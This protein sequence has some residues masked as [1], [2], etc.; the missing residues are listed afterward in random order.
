MNLAKYLALAVWGGAAVALALPPVMAQDITNHAVPVGGG[1]G[2]VGWKEAGPCSAGETLVWSSSSADPVCG[3]G[4]G[5]GSASFACAGVNDTATIQAVLNGASTTVV[6]PSGTC[7]TTAALTLNSR[8]SISC[9]DGG[10]CIL[11][12]VQPSGTTALTAFYFQSAATYST[13]S[14]IKITYACATCTTGFAGVI[15]SQAQYVT[16]DKMEI[17]GNKAGLLAGLLVVGVSVE[18]SNQIITNSF[19]HDT[20]SHGVTGNGAFSNILVDRNRIGTVGNTSLPISFSGSVSCAEHDWTFSNNYLDLSSMP[21]TGYSGIF[22]AGSTEICLVERVRILNNDCVMPTPPGTAQP[23]CYLPWYINNGLIQGNRAYYG[24]YAYTIAANHN[25]L[26]SQNASIGASICGFEMGG[27]NL[28][29]VNN[30]VDGGLV[31]NT[32]QTPVQGTC[33]FTSN[34]IWRAISTTA[35]NGGAIQITVVDTNFWYTGQL[36]CVVGVL[37]TVEANNCWTITVDNATHITLQGSAIKT[38]CTAGACGQGVIST[39]WQITAKDNDIANMTGIGIQYQYGAT[40]TTAIGNKITMAPN[41]GYACISDSSYRSIIVG[42]SCNG[43]SVPSSMDVTGMAAAAGLIR[44]TVASTATL[45][46]NSRVVIQGTLGTNEANNRLATPY[47]PVTVLGGGVTMDLQ[48]STFTNAYTGGGYIN[49]TRYGILRFASDSLAGSGFGGGVIANNSVY[50]TVK[51]CV[52]LEVTNVTVTNLNIWGN[53]CQNTVVSGVTTSLIGTGAIASTVST[54]NVIPNGTSGGVPTY[55][56]TGTL[57]SSGVLAANLP[58]IGGGAGAVIA[59]GTRSGTTTAF[60]TTTGAQT[61][62]DCVKIDASGN[63]VANGSSCGASSGVTINTTTITGGAAASVLYHTAGNVVGEYTVIGTASVCM[64]TNC[65]MTTPTL[66]AATATTINKVTF[67]APATGSTLTIADGKTALFNNTMAF[68]AGADGQTWTFPAAGAT[69]LTTNS[70]ATLTNKTFDT[71]ATGNALAL[72][73]QSVTSVSGNT[74][75]VVTTTGTL[76]SGDCV[77]IDASG[78]FIANGAACGSATSA[79]P[80]ATIGLT[81]VNGSA[82]TFL[83]SDGAPALSVAIAPTWTG[84]HTFNIGTTGA[85]APIIDAT[86]GGTTTTEQYWVINLGSNGA[87]YGG[88]KIKQAGTQKFVFYYNPGATFTTFDVGSAGA[89]PAAMKLYDTGGVAFGS[90]ATDPGAG[91]LNAQNGYVSGGNVGVD[92]TGIVAGTVTVSKGIV[93]HC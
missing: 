44:V 6:F 42:N 20:A 84:L 30:Y 8:K 83:R 65:I 3:A 1:P 16:I 90:T 5:G 21:D 37:L 31:V 7:K 68:S 80:S 40:D 79:N 86:S 58:L 32:V 49:M 59:A 23:S 45:T 11:Q 55:T 87:S 46:T 18:A 29:M 70:T 38:T 41:T 74:A 9:V 47:W 78:N 85:A 22:A 39:S 88:M 12:F 17:D 26:Y 28:S 63:H 36:A 35:S 71:A 72:G 13:I 25:T 51:G 4:G 93:T 75:K 2:A 81:A 54:V 89:V 33:G 15:R 64:T 60:V 66:G 48:G 50:G 77:K 92:C 52:Y 24:G 27:V 34:P 57:L 91:K 67:T 14:S 69:V 82:A 19:I 43:T 76:T 61:S 62:G 10:A 56:A 73:G 53:T